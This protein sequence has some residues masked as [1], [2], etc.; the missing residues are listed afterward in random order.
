MVADRLVAVG[1]ADRF[2]RF[3]FVD[4]KN[5]MYVGVR[6]LTH[7]HTRSTNPARIAVV[8]VRTVDVLGKSHN[9]WQSS[10]T[11]LAREKLGMAD[12]AGVCHP[13]K[14]LFQGLLADHILELHNAKIVFLL[15]LS[16]FLLKKSKTGEGIEITSIFALRMALDFCEIIFQG[17]PGLTGA[18][19]K[20]GGSILLKR[21]RIIS[22]QHD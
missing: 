17:I 1:A 21:R 5:E 8:P 22:L 18:I 3:R 7:L 4:R 2:G 13:D 16:L 15:F 12:P 19:L 9:Q 11:L 20:K 6:Q 10:R 14:A